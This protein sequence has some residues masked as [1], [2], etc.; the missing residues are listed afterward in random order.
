MIQEITITSQTGRGSITMTYGDRRGYWL[1]D[2]DWGQAEGSHNTYSYLNQIGANIVNTS[3]GTR[4]ISITGYVVE[5]DATI[6]SRCDALNVYFSPAEDY[7]LTYG[8]YKIAFRPDSSITWSRTYTENNTK[9]RKFLI[10]GTCPYPLF[11][12]V[13]DTE[14]QFSEVTSLFYFPNDLGSGDDVIY[15]LS[16][17]SYTITV[18]NTGGFETGV[19]IEIEFSAE[20]TNPKVYCGDSYV[21]VDYTFASGDVLEICTIPGQKHITLT[22]TDGDTNL[23]KYRNVG[24]SWWL[25]DPGENELTM[26]CDD[27]SE[28]GGMTVSVYFTPLYQEVE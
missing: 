14:E 3:I 24:M 4:S 21:G 19:T 28:L 16:A 27:V 2:V 5:K 17:S 23:M 25:L 15:G 7:W 8:D 20:V 6:T 26:T 18:D 10:Q 13:E 9:L 1:D 11:Q 12:E 22:N